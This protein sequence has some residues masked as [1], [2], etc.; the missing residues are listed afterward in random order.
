MELAGYI[1]FE[2]IATLLMILIAAGLWRL[3]EKAGRQGWEA[4][5]PIYN[6][7]I[8]IKLSGRPWWLL[9]FLF[10]PGVNVIIGF[11]ILIN[12]V[13]SYGKFNIWQHAAVVVLPFIYLPKWGFDK[14]TQYLGLAFSDEFREKYS[15]NLQK[16]TTREW[17]EAVLF[18]IVAATLI[19]TLFIEA[20]TIPTPSMEGSLMVGDYLFVSKVN[21]GA[22]LP[23]TAVSFPFVHNTMPNTNIPSYW[24][25]LL[26]P[27]FRLPGLSTVKKGDV[28]VFNY[29]MEADSPYYRP[30]DKQE[31]YIKRCQ[32]GPGD[33]LSVVNAQVYIN[34]KPE[35]TPSNGEMEYMVSTVDSNQTFR[36]QMIYELHLSN[37][38]QFTQVDYMMNMSAQ[39]AAR[40]K[41]YMKIRAIR[42]NIQPAGVYDPAEFPFNPH[43]RWNADNL[44]PIIIPKQ[45]WTVKLDS[46]TLP[47]YR[48][49]IEVYEHNKLKVDGNNITINGIRT[50]SYT[51]KMNYYWMMGDNRHNS[52]DSRYWGFVPEDHIVGKALFVWMSWDAQSPSI[53]KIRWSRVMRWIK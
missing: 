19:R 27:Y 12:F 10:I 47:F 53:N 17:S 4:V 46:L 37:V 5:I 13:K 30:V 20:Y 43:Y 23:I 7:Y 26:L 29:P 32:G 1:G 24:R 35:L 11:S 2:I 34:G 45:G 39:S 41:D 52:V 42:A 21:Y 44:G 25:G 36:P 40:L 16:S 51:F 49:A 3:F 15:N 28:V 31:N 33:T 8:M 50:N 18:A 6:I 38:Q 14:S 48:R 22:R 9:L